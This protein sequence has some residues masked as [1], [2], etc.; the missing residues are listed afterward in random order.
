MVESMMFY[1]FNQDT[2]TARLI[3]SDKSIDLTK[4]QQKEFEAWLE[5][6]IKEGVK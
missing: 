2:K 6:K 3:F 4:V 1:V 5:Y